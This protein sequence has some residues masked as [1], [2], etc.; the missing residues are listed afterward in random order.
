[1]L[2]ASALVASGS[3]GLSQGP[4]VKEGGVR[5]PATRRVFPLVRP[6]PDGKGSPLDLAGV[7][8]RD[9][10]GSAYYAIGLYVDRTELKRSLGPRRG[11]EEAIQAILRRGVAVC[12]DIQY[13]QNIS[14]KRRVEIIREQFAK[15]WKGEGAF[16]QQPGVA[17][18]LTHLHRDMRRGD[19]SLIWILPGGKLA[20]Q[21]A[22]SGQATLLVSPHAQ[23]LILA[24]YFGS[25]SVSRPLKSD[26]FARLA[27]VLGPE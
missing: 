5:E 18:F 6:M 12:L 19:E 24:V 10:F 1:M 9:K 23:E 15:R 4:A 8:H 16:D 13:L 27:T 2:L 7:G 17:E 22:H 20:V 25:D 26:L 21:D 11:A 14:G 3:F